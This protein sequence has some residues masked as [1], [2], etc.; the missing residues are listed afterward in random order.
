MRSTAPALIYEEGDLIK[1]A[2]RDLY[3]TRHRRGAGRGRGGLPAPP[4]TSCAMLMPQPGEQGR[5]LQGAD[6]ALPPLPG[7]EPAR[8]DALAGRAAALRRLHRHQPDRGAGRHRRQLGP[9]DQGAQ[10]RG[11]GAQDQPRGGRGD[12]PPGAPARPRRPDRD[13]LHRH[14]GDAP[15]APGRAQGQGR[16]AQRPRPHPDRPHLGRSACSRCRASGCGPACSSIRPRSARIAPA[17]AASARSNR[18]RCTR[19]APSRRKA[20]AGAASEIVRQR[21]AQRRALPPQPEAPHPVGDREALR[22][23]GDHRGRRRAACRRLRDRA[24]ARRAATTASGRARSWRAPPT[25]R[26]PTRRRPTRPKAPRTARPASRTDDARR[27]ARGSD[28][29]DGRRRRRRRRRRGG[30]RDEDGDSDRPQ[31]MGSED[32]PTIVARTQRQRCGRRSAQ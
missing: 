29:R 14:G 6:P 21:A 25:T 11:D 9:L 2:M 12:R 28:D 19:C 17:P 32:Q 24:R 3:D 5:A 22:L 26:S 23:L 1:R 4:A 18:R 27:R 15:P 8:R 31:A 7:R 10:H 13:R 16:D 20:C 30:R